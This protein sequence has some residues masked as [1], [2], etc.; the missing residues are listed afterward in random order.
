MM[1]TPEPFIEEA[2]DVIVRAAVQRE[3]TKGGS[4]TNGRAFADAIKRS[5]LETKTAIPGSLKIAYQAALKTLEPVVT[6]NTAAYHPWQLEEP[7]EPAATPEQRAHWLAI[8]AAKL[9]GANGELASSLGSVVHIAPPVVD[10]DD[11]IPGY[12]DAA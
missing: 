11:D 6:A 7:T 1:T 9:A 8:I 12:G 10:D 4:V 2:L 5:H 3:Y